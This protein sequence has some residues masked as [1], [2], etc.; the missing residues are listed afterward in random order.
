MYLMMY[1]LLA[2]HSILITD[3]GKGLGKGAIIVIYSNR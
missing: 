1:I 3:A 2:K